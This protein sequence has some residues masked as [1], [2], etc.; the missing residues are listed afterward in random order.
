VTSL[1]DDVRTDLL[2]AARAVRTDRGQLWLDGI[3]LGT[4]GPATGRVL[5]DALYLRWFAQATGTLRGPVPPDISLVARLRAAHAASERFEDGWTAVADPLGK[6]LAKRAWE[7][8]PLRAFDYANVSRPGSPVQL[9]DRLAM[10]GRRDVVDGPNGWWM[11][12]GSAGPPRGAP[13][14]RVYWNGGADIVAELTRRITGLL[15]DGGHAYSM[16]CPSAAPLFER[17]DSI[18][19]YLDRPTWSRARSGLRAVHASLETALH[20]QTPPLTRRL[21]R[22]VAVAEDPG[23]GRSFGQ[24]RAI[25][26]ASGLMR[27]LPDRLAD[28]GAVVEVLAAALAAHR[29][30]PTRPYLGAASSSTSDDDWSWDHTEAQDVTS[31]DRWSAPDGPP[32]GQHGHSARRAVHLGRR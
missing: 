17:V 24:S 2:A 1:P 26:L 21:G 5:A 12:M 30:S 23:G 8:R 14:V 11:T 9:G 7:L 3:S 19:V 13:L 18:V 10:S 31:A 27:L 4:P 32:P 16:K 6:L 20:P 29:I 25:A 22:G 15:E 28:E